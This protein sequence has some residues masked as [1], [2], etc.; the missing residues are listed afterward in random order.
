VRELKFI[1]G[2][3]KKEKL[4]LKIYNISNHHIFLLVHQNMY[5]LP[6]FKEV[7]K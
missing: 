1:Y 2:C 6:K 4:K 3:E 5:L 7:E